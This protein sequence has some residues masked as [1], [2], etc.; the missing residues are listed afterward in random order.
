MRFLKYSCRS[1]GFM[2]RALCLL[3]ALA[4]IATPAAAQ[5][6]EQPQ[7]TPD[8][9][10]DAFYVLDGTDSSVLAARHERVPM[11]IASITK[12]MTALVVLEAGQDMDETLAIT[13][14][15]L[16]AICRIAPVHR[17]D[18]GGDVLRGCDAF[19]DQQFTH[20]NFHLLPIRQR[21]V[22][23]GTVRMT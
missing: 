15:D 5:G 19:F 21:R 14:D 12:L 17:L 10:S 11:P 6:A 9:R 18:L 8:V 22:I 1:A 7:A 4:S 23:I 13:R 2:V 3:V 20:G 16:R